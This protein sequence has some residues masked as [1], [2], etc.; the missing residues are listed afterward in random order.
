M[1]RLAHYLKPFMLLIGLSLVLLFVQAMSDLTLPDY[2][3][4]IVNT[5]IQQSGVESPLP[6]AIRQSELEK[7]TLFMATED[8]AELT[9]A[10][11][12]ITSESANYAETVALYPTLASEPVYLL[13]EVTESERPRLEELVTKPLLIVAGIYQ[14]LENPEAA[15]EGG[16]DL[17]GLPAGQDPFEMLKGLPAGMRSQMLASAEER[18]SAL[19]PAFLT[20]GAIRAVQA[21][22]TALG[23]DIAGRQQSYILNKGGVMLLISLLSGASTVAVGYLSARAAAGMARN[24]RRDVFTK[25]DSFS[26]TEFDQF[27]VSSLITRSTNDVAQLQMLVVILLR[28]VVYAPILAI[29]GIIKAINTDV[30]MW[31]TIALAVVALLTLI[32][33]TFGLALPKF[34]LIQKLVDRLNLVTREHLSGMMVIRAFN[35]QP[36]EE[37]RFDQANIELTNT[38]LYV[39][40]VVVFMMPAMMFIMNGVSVLIIWVGAHR[41]AEAQMQVGNMMAFMQYAMQIVTAFLILSF[42]FIILPRASVSADR[43][44]DVLETKATILDPVVPQTFPA[45]FKGTVE[46][47]E[48]SFAYPGAEE[49]VL[50]NISFTA[51]PGQT[52]AFIGSTGSGKST[53]INLIPR[54]YDVTAGAILVNG[55]DIRQVRQHELREK[56]GFI[57]QK[58]NL[59]SGTIES[60]LRYADD[61]APLE[62]L[63]QA[64]DIAQATP[65]ILEKTERFQSEISQGG[66]NVSGG[67]RQRLAIARALVKQA[68]IY[69]FDDSFSALDFKT[70]SALRKALKKATGGST[71][72]IVA[73]RISTIKTAEQIIVLDEGKVVG[74]GTHQELMKNCET[75]REIALSQLS[76]EELSQ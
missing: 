67:Q 56:I 44:A 19:E 66:S 34:R 14:A 5:G 30:A 46:F 75:Y 7:V 21:E 43:I 4:Q 64:A 47:R 63:Q 37:K 36:F 70:D 41:V 76:A 31:W 6:E 71:L 72:L 24:L 18:F 51:E 29:G 50:Q 52:T 28:M 74:K 3:A 42:M 26:S 38:N 20:Q 49:N 22:Y 39:N 55:V 12:L 69:I 17:S 68:P 23:V 48:V 65:F 11:T 1:I 53:L 40:R 13:N 45:P 59:F 54:F 8:A 9:A 16:L 25:V 2:M 58:G 10:Y 60:N 35:T 27:S 62:K 15:A 73:Q 57:P 32:F 33:T 61:Q